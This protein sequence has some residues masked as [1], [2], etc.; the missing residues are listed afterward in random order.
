MT[1]THALEIVVE[2]HVQDTR[3]EVP[4][5]A[6]SQMPLRARQRQDLICFERRCEAKSTQLVERRAHRRVAR[7]RGRE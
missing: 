5:S 7:P 3:P 6:L 1:L 4:D 2:R